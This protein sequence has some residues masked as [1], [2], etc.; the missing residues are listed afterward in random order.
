MIKVLIWGMGS[1]YNKMR[2]ILSYYEMKKE[3]LIVGITAK[4]IPHFKYV[5]GIEILSYENIKSVNFDYI[6]V[7]SDVYFKEI[8]DEIVKIG[9]STNQILKYNF[10]EIP[11][12]NVSEYLDIKK[13]KITIFSN[14]CWAGMLY[15]TLG[16]ECL[17]PTK[18][19]FIREDDYLRF[20]E[21]PKFYLKSEVIFKRWEIDSNIQK[22]YP[23]LM[24]KDIE[25]HCN[26]KDEIGDAIVE[27]KR[28][29]VKVNY[30]CMYAEM[31][32]E[33]VETANKFK[34]IKGYKGKIC[35]VPWKTEEQDL[36]YL[37]KLPGQKH[38]WETVNNSI[39]VCSNGYQ[40]D[41]ISIFNENKVYRF[42]E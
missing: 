13:R 6:I 2:N 3:M 8:F 31:Y 9:I 19:L 7:M 34:Q 4:E 16:L 17:S 42:Q 26:H 29:C 28:R 23:V 1:I 24:C 30:D 15:K 40:V 21:N 32:T 18:N 39:A 20:L 10:L 11:Y 25:I 41:V 37:K 33:N 22:K 5:D 12:L 14:N 35:F 36:I 38:F 27:W